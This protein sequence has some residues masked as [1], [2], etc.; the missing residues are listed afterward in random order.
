MR[1]INLHPSVKI[2]AASEIQM[3]PLI[4]NSVYSILVNVSVK[5]PL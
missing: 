1:G 3:L 2:K 4:I 5:S